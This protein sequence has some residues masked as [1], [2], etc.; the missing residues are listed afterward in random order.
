LFFATALIV[1]GA[2]ITAVEDS[3][4]F[5]QSQFNNYGSEADLRVKNDIPSNDGFNRKSYFRFDLSGYLGVSSDATLELQSIDSGQGVTSEAVYTFQVFGLNT[6]SVNAWTENTLTWFNAPAN[7]SGGTGIDT[8][9]VVSLGSFQLTGKGVGTV[10]FSTPALRAYLN[11]A[12]AG[13]ETADFIIFRDNDTT[14]GDYI[15]AF[16]SRENS[17]VSGP[18]LNF[19]PVPEPSSAVVCGSGLFGLAVF[20]RRRHSGDRKSILG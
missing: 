18:Q 20:L 3:Y 5:S 9:K 13:G 15:H 11:A 2:S 17:E 14:N 8:S 10:L 19:T 16:A 7:M 12:I 4:I 1:E 6:P